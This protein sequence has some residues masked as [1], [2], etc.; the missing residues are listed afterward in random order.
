MR[1]DTTSHPIAMNETFCCGVSGF[2]EMVLEFEFL[3]NTGKTHPVDVVLGDG[4]SYCFLIC[5]FPPRG[6]QIFSAIDYFED[7]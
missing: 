6:M 7:R 5:G 3:S 1:F 4:K 2:H